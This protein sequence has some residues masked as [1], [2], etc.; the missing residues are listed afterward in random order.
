[1]Y[2]IEFDKNMVESKI[3]TSFHLNGE[4]FKAKPLMH[5]T[6]LAEA[7]SL[8]KIGEEIKFV[9]EGCPIDLEDESEMQLVD[10]FSN[11]DK[12]I[13]LEKKEEKIFIE[14]GQEE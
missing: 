1:M 9:S 7:R 10:I 5:S 11:S 2:N 3:L 8:L 6:T 4:K 12:C 13:H 14:Q